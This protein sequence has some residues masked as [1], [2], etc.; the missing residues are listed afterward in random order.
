MVL[1]VGTHEREFTRENVEGKK[2]QWGFGVGSAK[3]LRL[4]AE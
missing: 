3:A 1:K 2:E 4:V